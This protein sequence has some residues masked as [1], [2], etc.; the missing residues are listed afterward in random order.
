MR[1]LIISDIHSN[2]AALEAVLEAT[3]EAEYGRVWCLGDIVGYG[4]D[5]NECVTQVRDLEAL[6]IAGNH[7]WAALERIPLEDF[8]IDAQRATLWTRD[9]LTAKSISYLQG[10]PETRVEGAFTLAHG[11]PRHPI[12]EYIHLPSVAGANFA[13]FSTPYCLVGHSHIPVIF[14]ELDD[15]QAEMFFPPLDVPLTLDERRLIINPGSVG[16]PRDGDPRASYLL[17]DEEAGTVQFQRV[18]YPINHTQTRM[19]A[20]GLPPRLAARLAFGW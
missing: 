1:I 4:P 9:Q 17:L 8:N 3:E 13:Y 16:Q 19:M 2:V 15:H 5:P 20:A 7:D 12:W 14:R 10:P 11:S 6:C 18:E